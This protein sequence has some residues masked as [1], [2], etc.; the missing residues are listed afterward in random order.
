MLFTCIPLTDF[1]ALVRI[2]IPP[3]LCLTHFGAG[4]FRPFLPLVFL[5]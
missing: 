4:F 5:T 3:L 1:S 2:L